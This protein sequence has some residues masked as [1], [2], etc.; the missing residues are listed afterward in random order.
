[1]KLICI[2]FIILL[3]LMPSEQCQQ[4]REDLQESNSPVSQSK[5]DKAMEA[6]DYA[7]RLDPNDT[8][9]WN[10]KGSALFQLGKYNES[11]TCFDEAIRLDPDYA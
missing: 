11:I 5:Y 6:F 9:A 4:T 7:I 3:A 10:D 2:V 1:M 8:T